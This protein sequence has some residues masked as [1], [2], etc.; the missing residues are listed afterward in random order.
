M[1]LYGARV[2]SVRF[3]VGPAVYLGRVRTW[4][5]EKERAESSL[6]VECLTSVKSGPRFNLK[7]KGESFNYKPRAEVERSGLIANAITE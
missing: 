4:V 5:A 7:K 2:K 1:Q 6:Y 3:S